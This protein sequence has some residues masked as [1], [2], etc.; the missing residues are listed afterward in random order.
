MD[1]AIKKRYGGR[2]R[3]VIGIEILYTPR[4]DY[5]QF[6]FSPGDTGFRVFDTKYCRLAPL[7]CWDQWF[8]GAA[9]CVAL[10]GAE[11]L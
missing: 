4:F 10:M 7:I 2:L 11:V 3:S 6:Y 9:A 1:L 5:Y 8:S